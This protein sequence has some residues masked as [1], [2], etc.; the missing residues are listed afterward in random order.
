M[1]MVHYYIL[2]CLLLHDVNIFLQFM[3]ITFINTIIKFCVC[4]Y[5]S[6][7]FPYVDRIL[8]RPNTNE[9]GMPS[10]HCQLYFALVAYMPRDYFVPMVI[11]GCLIAHERVSSGK[12][13]ILQVLVGS[14]LGYMLG[15]LT[16]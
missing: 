14:V 10:G 3:G 11:Y 13:T 16:N 12:H 9:Y 1:S 7:R 4:P 15:L 8:L 2:P 5:L 6:N